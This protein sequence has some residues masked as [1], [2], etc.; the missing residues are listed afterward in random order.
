M[1]YAPRMPLSIDVTET[2]RGEHELADPSAGSAG[3]HAMYFRLTWKNKVGA[4]PWLLGRRVRPHDARGVIFVE[5]LTDGEVPCAGT[6][7][8]DYFG[9]KKI[10]YELSFEARGK[11]YRLHAEKVNVDL[12]KPLALLKTHT[13]CYGTLTDDAGKVVSRSVLRFEK[14]ALGPMLRS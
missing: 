13:T 7:A 1:S 8:L 11:R 2:M 3:A 14:D 9:E 4:L 12:R 5:G 6:L 10:V